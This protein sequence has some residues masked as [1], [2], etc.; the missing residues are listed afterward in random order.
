MKGATERVF[1]HALAEFAVEHGNE[2]YGA[3]LVKDGMPKL[4]NISAEDIQ[5]VPKWL[6]GLSPEIE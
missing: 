5:S 2:P 3:A 1:R 6:S 4:K